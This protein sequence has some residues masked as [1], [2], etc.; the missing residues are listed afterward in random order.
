VAELRAASEKVLQTRPHLALQY[1]P[2]QGYGPLIDYLRQRIAQEEGLSLSR[3]NFTL[4]AGCADAIDRVCCQWLQPGDVVI[5]EAP[6][7]F[8]TL[9]IFQDHGAVPVSVPVDEGGLMVEVLE[10]RLVALDR[11]GRRPR[12][13]YTIPS[14][15]NPTGVTLAADRRPELIRLAREYGFFIVEDDVYRDLS[16]EGQVPA[17]LL[18]LDQ[19]AGGGNVFRIGSFSKILAPGLRLGWLIGPPCLIK[20]IYESGVRC[21]GGGANPFICH[22]VSELC[23][24]GFLDSHIENLRHLYRERRDIMLKALE[25][26]LP[27]QVEWTRPAG[28]FFIWLQLPRQL[29][30]QAVCAAADAAGVTV[31][32]GDQFYADNDDHHH[33]RL[34][35][36]YLTVEEIK[37]GVAALGRVMHELLRHESVQ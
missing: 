1:G 5:V 27:S 6:S 30:S 33:I 20:D 19:Q 29:T 26:H 11:A 23:L 28:G 8:E 14:F 36:S 10:K 37:Q 32:P 15:Q 2:Q 18:A 24:S 31:L 21:T 7:Y 3:A 17:S 35:F 25:V 22:T 13:L 4:T 12:L 34:A 16:Y 9:M